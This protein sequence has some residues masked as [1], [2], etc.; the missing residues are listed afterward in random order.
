MTVL[1]AVT[2]SVEGDLAL[3][4]GVAEADLRGTTLIVANLRLGPIAAPPEAKVIERAPNIDVAEHVLKLLDEYAGEVE[5]LVIGM[6][7]RSPVGKAVL[8]SIAQRLLLTA[9]VPVL[10]VKT[11]D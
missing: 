7:R 8:G 2:D 3:A 5:L 6:K 11:A 9:N 10:A 4:R 1:V